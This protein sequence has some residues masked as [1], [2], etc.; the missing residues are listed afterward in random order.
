M[1]EPF[2]YPLYLPG[3]KLQ[4]RFSTSDQSP[5][6][7]SCGVAG[8]P[9]LNRW[10]PSSRMGIHVHI[11][12]TRAGCHLCNLL[13]ITIINVFVSRNISKDTTGIK[14]WDLAPN[15]ININTDTSV[16]LNVNIDIN[17]S[18]QHL[19]SLCWV[20]I[21]IVSELCANICITTACMGTTDR[22][23]LLTPTFF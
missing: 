5:S 18:H 4:W 15:M 17:I 19:S 3:Q 13:I 11:I 10:C 23:G 7:Y 1:V 9:I 6:S 12:S 14:W 22:Q 16:D 2:L 21:F 20:S 8:D